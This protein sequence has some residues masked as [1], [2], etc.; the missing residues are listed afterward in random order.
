MKVIQ[1]TRHYDEMRNITVSIRSKEEAHDYRYFPE[2]DLVPF[3]IAD[4]VPIIKA[5]LPELPDAKRERFKQQYGLSDD[6]AKSLTSEIKVANFYEYVAS[7]TPPKPAAVWT[8]DVLKGELNYRS[9]SIDLFDPDY[10]IEIV[11]MLTSNGL[12]EDNAVEIIRTILDTGGNPKEIIKAKGLTKA[13]E[14]VVLMAVKEAV[15]ECDT[16]IADFKAGS[17]RALNFIV[18]HV[19]KKTHGR[20]DPANVHKLVMDEIKKL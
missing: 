14:D 4:W 10:M 2:P 1:E 12:T 6:H 3:R 19:M 8:A 16:A 7:R 5:Q 18:G 9:I 13:E 15:A 11:N 17:P 20:A